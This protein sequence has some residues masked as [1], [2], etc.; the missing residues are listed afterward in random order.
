MEKEIQV[1]N[2]HHLKQE[3]DKLQQDLKALQKA[4]DAI[5]NMPGN[6]SFSSLEKLE[7]Q[8]RKDAGEITDLKVKVAQL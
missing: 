7:R 6:K 5:K 1:K 4:H 8:A 2:L 3:R